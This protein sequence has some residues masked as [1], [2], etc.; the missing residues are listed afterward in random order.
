[1]KAN[2]PRR[3]AAS[4]DLDF[5]A[6]LLRARKVVEIDLGAVEWFSPLGVVAVLSFC[7]RSQERGMR[8]AVY[9]PH[10]RLVRSYLDRIGFY[11]ELAERGW[12]GT[13]NVTTD[14][15]YQV[16]ACLPVTRL[17]TQSQVERATEALADNLERGSVVQPVFT[18]VEDTMTEL[19]LN[20]REH[21]SVSYAVV[22]T[23]TGRSSG[24]PGVH[25]AVADFGPGFAATLRAK[26]GHLA[27]DAAVMKGFEERVTSLKSTGRGLGLGFV[28]EAI[29]GHRGATLTIISETG[30]VLL[31]GGIFH[32]ELG[33]KLSGTI[34]AAYFPYTPPQP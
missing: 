17:S 8:T 19:S 29:D 24:T 4:E 20:A 33:P 26:Y 3:V 11:G 32:S 25:I 5:L 21:G 30:R 13:E 10:S 7:L 34:A 6:P 15:G 22:Q 27:D 31:E 16:Q 18:A 2:A 28:Q 9:L 23:H 12:S 14:E 1:M